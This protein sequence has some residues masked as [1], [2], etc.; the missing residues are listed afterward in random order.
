MTEPPV[1]APTEVSDD[2]VTPDA[3]V[4]P[5]SVPAGATTALPEAAVIRPLALTVNDGIEVDE[6]NE[7][8]LLLTVANVAAQLDVVISPV[9]AG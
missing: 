6:P 8:T 7:P 4:A 1:S 3:S 5:V 2:A 9:S